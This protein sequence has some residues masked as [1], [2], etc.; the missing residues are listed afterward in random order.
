M[1]Y[2]SSYLFLFAYMNS[3]TQIIYG[4]LLLYCIWVCGKLLENSPWILYAESIKWLFLILAT[5]LYAPQ[6]NFDALGLVVIM[7]SVISLACFFLLKNKK[8]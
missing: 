6:I 2:T 3:K 7:I 1:G 5:L 8:A 4:V